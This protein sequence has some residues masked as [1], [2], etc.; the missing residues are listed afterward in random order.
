MHTQEIR[1]EQKKK[2]GS[3][4]GLGADWLMF[5][6]GVDSVR[7]LS[8]PNLSPKFCI[9][10]PVGFPSLAMCF[11]WP[12]FLDDSNPPF[13]PISNAIH[14]TVRRAHTQPITQKLQL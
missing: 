11:P 4:E 8:S 6:F 14:A 5:G 7:S 1:T 12:S 3:R 2:D 9:A 10:S 13:P